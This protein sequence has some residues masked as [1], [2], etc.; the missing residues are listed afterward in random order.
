[1]KENSA[2][3][4]FVES[5]YKRRKNEE[6]TKKYINRIAI[7]ENDQF[8][9]IAVQDIKFSM[10]ELCDESKKK[11]ELSL[12]SFETQFRKVKFQHCYSKVPYFDKP[13]KY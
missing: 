11:I 8:E 5:D 6:L 2:F 13:W 4:F 9:I 3:I 10:Y 12:K 7:E 1:M